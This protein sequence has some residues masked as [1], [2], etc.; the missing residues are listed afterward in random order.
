[1]HNSVGER[2]ERFPERHSGP[3]GEVSRAVGGVPPPSDFGTRPGR[4]PC[5]ELCSG[6]GLKRSE[7]RVVLWHARTCNHCHEREKRS[8]IIKCPWRAPDF[9]LSTR[10][11][12]AYAQSQRDQKGCIPTVGRSPTGNECQPPW[13]PTGQHARSRVVKDSASKINEG[14][15]SG[16]H[17]FNLILYI[18]FN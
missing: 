14:W 15:R 2:A 18:R 17:A 6:I 7:V 4:V 5:E 16:E 10:A 12:R 1:M 13:S 9:P 3:V 8:A 11:H